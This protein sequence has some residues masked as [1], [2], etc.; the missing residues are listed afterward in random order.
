MG[1]LLQA[2]YRRSAGSS[3]PSPADGDASVPWWWD[4]LAGQAKALRLCG[5][6]AVLLPPV[7][8]TS[9]GVSPDADGYGT[10]DDY[11]LGNKNQFFSVPTRFGTR[12]QLQRCVAVMRANGLDVYVDVVLH[13]RD[14]GNN[15]VYQ[16]LGADGVTHDGRFPKQHG[17]FVGDPAHGYVGRDPLPGPVADDYAFGD[18]LA[19]IN[20][21]PKDYV[22][23]GLVD[24][25]DWL[26]RALGVQGYRVDDVKGLA[27]DFLRGWLTSKAMAGKFGAG[28]YYDGNP[29]TLNWW[30]WQ[31]GMS[32]RCCAFDFALHFVVRAMCNNTSQWDM[33]Q[34]DHA[35]LAGISPMQ[36]VTFVENPDT[37]T[38]GYTGVT[39]NKMLGYAYILTSEGYPCVYYKDYSTDAGCYGLKPYIDNLVWIHENLAFGTTIQRWKDYQCFVFER[40]GYPNLLVGLNNDMYSGWRTVTV[41]TNFGPNV[42]LHDYA[43]RAGDVWTDWSGAVTIGIP[44]NDNGLGYVCYSRTGYGQAF[45]ATPLETTQAFEGAT[46]LDIGPAVN[47]ATVHVGRLW[48]AAGATVEAVLAAD[49][50]GWGA[51]AAIL[52]DLVDGNGSVLATGRHPTGSGDTTFRAKALH[53]GWLTVQ[54]RGAGLPASGAPFTLTMKYTATQE[55]GPG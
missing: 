30:V 7:L 2:A 25:G 28:E 32:G 40:Q 33:S 38:D 10:Y 35:G 9:A 1:V 31:S 37:D 24:A 44:P 49:T 45:S 6:T 18:E 3:A 16:Y 21:V 8:K 48:C 15:G 54:I 22:R 46:D 19:P 53:S 11:D 42:Q 27:V 55:V 20:A 36:A 23:N 52:A 43:G 5:F 41:Q 12:E 51:Q 14:G 17:C 26:T 34:L 13:Q 29:D 39:W 4:H 47:G 50:G